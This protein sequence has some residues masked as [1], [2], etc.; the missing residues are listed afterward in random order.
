MTNY[1]KIKAMSVEDVSTLL[2][3]VTFF[4]RYDE[5]EKCPINKFKS[6]FGCSDVSIKQWLESEA[7]EE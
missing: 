4:C 5:C 7:D 6:D 1:E 3:D 2:N